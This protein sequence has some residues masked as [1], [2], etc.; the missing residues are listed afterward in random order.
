VSGSFNTMFHR[1]L[2]EASHVKSRFLTTG[3]HL[4][5]RP[6]V[7]NDGVARFV[8][9]TADR[10]DGVARFVLITTVT[11]DDLGAFQDN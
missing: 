7:R 10:N 1:A 6:L 11:H 5:G 3:P 8:F 9:L 4:M 2:C